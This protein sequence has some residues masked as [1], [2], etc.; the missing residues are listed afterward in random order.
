VT[1]ESLR[2]LLGAHYALAAFLVGVVIGQWN[3]ARTGEG[4]GLGSAIL[5]MVAVAFLVAATMIRR[6]GGGGG[7]SEG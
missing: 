2:R 1:P 6:L 5:V 4:F 3:G 7:A